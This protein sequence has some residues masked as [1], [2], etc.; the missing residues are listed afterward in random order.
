MGGLRLQE[1]EWSILFS[2]MD[3]SFIVSEKISADKSAENMAYCRNF[4]QRYF[5]KYIFSLV[6]P[7]VMC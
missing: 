4:L 1:E 7:A 6:I 3:G 2:Y 5:V